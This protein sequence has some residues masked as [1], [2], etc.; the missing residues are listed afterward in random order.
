VQCLG[1]ADD[2]DPSVNNS[3]LGDGTTEHSLTPIT[4][5]GITTA[6]AISAG[7]FYTCALLADQTVD[8]WG[9]NQWGELGHSGPEPTVPVTIV[10]V[11][12]G[13]AIATGQYHMCAAIDGGTVSCWGADNYGQLGDGLP[14]DNSDPFNPAFSADPS[15]VASISDAVG[16][17]TGPLSVGS[18]RICVRATNSAVAMSAGTTCASLIISNRPIA[19]HLAY[20]GPTHATRGQ[21]LTLEATLRTAGGTGIAGQTMRFTLSGRT[22]SATTTATGIASVVVHAPASGGRY[23]IVVRYAGSSSYAAA[24][25]SLASK[26]TVK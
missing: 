2:G 13:N 26:F 5:T 8:C 17:S 12:G 7:A 4:V 9:V 6:T 16:P 10:G 15:P 1:G 18:H 24:S 21:R 14:I 20:N 3:L 11:R 19:T 23:T 22:Y 25:L